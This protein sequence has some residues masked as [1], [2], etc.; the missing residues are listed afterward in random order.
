VRIFLNRGQYV[1]VARCAFEID[2]QRKVAIAFDAE[3]EASLA[4]GLLFLT[5]HTADPIL[6]TLVNG[7]HV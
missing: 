2:K 6:Q 3:F 5:L 1:A 4:C 7:C